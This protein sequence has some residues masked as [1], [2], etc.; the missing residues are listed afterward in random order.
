MHDDH[1][2]LH[3]HRLVHQFKLCE[4]ANTEGLNLSK[5]VFSTY[6]WAGLYHHILAGS[7]VGGAVV[8]R[9]R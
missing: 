4:A 6:L 7:C 8:R 2:I 3:L 5:S 9:E 1:H